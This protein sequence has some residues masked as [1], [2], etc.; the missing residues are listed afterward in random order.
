MAVTESA[1]TR[2]TLDSHEEHREKPLNNM[3]YLVRSPKEAEEPTTLSIFR[4]STVV[5]LRD[6]ANYRR[7]HQTCRLVVGV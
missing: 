3:D 5:T 1:I 4:M 2:Q 6:G 7:T